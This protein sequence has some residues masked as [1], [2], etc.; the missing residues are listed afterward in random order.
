MSR[1]PFKIAR[2]PL[3]AAKGPT[4]AAGK[5]GDAQAPDP[6][7]AAS[8][9]APR[10]RLRL[11]DLNP[12]YYCSVI[13]TCLGTGE[14]R[15]LMARFVVTDGASDLDIHHDAVRL[16]SHSSAAAR[17]L[18]KALDARHARAIRAFSEAQDAA[19]L[20]VLWDLACTGGEIPG[21]YWALLTHRSVTIDLRQRAFGDVHMLSHLVGAANRADLRRL[22]SLEAALEAAR[23][24][25]EER[26]L[27]ALRLMDER[28]RR[29]R[30]LQREMD[31][32]RA[33]L[34]AARFA[35][36]A[37][38]AGSAHRSELE[39][40]AALVALQTE[41][42][43][44]AEQAAA[45]AAA[46]VS[47]LEAALAEF[48]QHALLLRRELAAAECQLQELSGADEGRE[49]RLA[50]SLRG[51]RV[52]YVGGRPSSTPAIRDLVLRN[53]GEFRHHDGGLEDRKGLL[54][55]G[56]GWA[57]M[58]VFP[59][60][61]IDHDSAGNLKRLC[62]RQGVP[63]LA[64]RGASVATFAAALPGWFGDDPDPGGAPARTC[65]RHG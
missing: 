13:G 46:H 62:T 24:E 64:L 55:A 8:D 19:G 7:A 14:L 27:R 51:R 38:P 18:S 58:V 36:D 32:L 29:L 43:E 56:I 9:T 53:G 1:P 35:A 17:A 59:V 5:A 20:A 52:L 40:A 37:V 21:A 25:S 34:A 4:D 63:Y 65:I 44:R 11:A 50:R 45:G 3:A 28:D 49:R 2:T 22:A 47:R 41:R 57:Q 23:A 15:R 42:R 31:D 61:C 26:S 54:A 6:D 12:D 16:A 10:G 30:D 48:S 33:Q 39:S 60:D